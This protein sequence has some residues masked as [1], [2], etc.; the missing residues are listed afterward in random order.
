MNAPF[1]PVASKLSQ[2]IKLKVAIMNGKDLENIGN[3]LDGKEFKG[4]IIE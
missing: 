1:D 2:E 3:Y 4:T